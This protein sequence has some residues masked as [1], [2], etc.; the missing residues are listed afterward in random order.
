M[1]GFLEKRGIPEMAG[2]L[3]TL[4]GHAGQFAGSRAR[5]PRLGPI[6]GWAGSD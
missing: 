2:I 1:S 6:P 4:E 3:E 5:I